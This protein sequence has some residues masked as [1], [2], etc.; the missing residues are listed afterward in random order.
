[1]NFLNL[2]FVFPC[3]SITGTSSQQN[4]HRGGKAK[5]RR[6]NGRGPGIVDECNGT[7]AA[8]A[9]REDSGQNI[10]GLDGTTIFHHFD[11]TAAPPGL[12]HLT[13]VPE[14][15]RVGILFEEHIGDFTQQFIRKPRTFDA[16][17]GI[18][19]AGES[20][21]EM[22]MN[23]GGRNSLASHPVESF[24]LPRS[25]PQGHGS[26]SSIG[27]WNWSSLDVR[28]LT[29][30]DNTSSIDNKPFLF[31]MDP[32]LHPKI[33]IETSKS[34]SKSVSISPKN[35]YHIAL[36]YVTYACFWAVLAVAVLTC[37]STVSSGNY[38]QMKIYFTFIDISTQLAVMVGIV[39]GILGI[40]ALLY[41]ATIFV[42]LVL[43]LAIILFFLWH[44]AGAWLGR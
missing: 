10:I 27:S 40:L 31:D 29:H 16:S 42:S 36:R 12:T 15:C 3:S 17:V 43:P 35:Y 38:H 19:H 1:M 18:H 32:S 30:D 21:S 23:F 8:A 41:L 13:A 14:A 2:N 9:A 37:R 39:V 24:Q 5:K 44:L 28:S 33:G 6:V 26:S 25:A 20:N 34:I 22:N 7:A 4:N 11:T